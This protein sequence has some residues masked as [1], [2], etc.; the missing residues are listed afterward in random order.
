MRDEPPKTTKPRRLSISRKVI[1]GV[2]FT[3]LMLALI[4][5]T[6]FIS[7][8]R[9][10][11]VS[12]EVAQRRETLERI[13]RV[14]RYFMEMENGVRGYLL[15]GDDQHLVPYEHGQS[16]IVQELQELRKSTAEQEDQQARVERLQSSLSRAFAVHGRSIEERREGGVARAAE[17]FT[18]PANQR[19][20]EQ[21]FGMIRDEL[22][23]FDQAERVRLR[24]DMDQLDAI[25]RVNTSLV[26]G[27][28]SLTYIALLVACLFVLR[29]IAERRRAEDAL[30]M[31]RNL[32]QS[33]MDT[34]PDFIIVKDRAGKY[35]R[36]NEAYCRHL[37]L[38][39]PEDARSKT[40]FDF[41]PREFA[42]RYTSDE[43]RVLETGEP[44]SDKIEPN[45]ASDGREVWLETTI[46]PLR[47]GSGQPMGVVALSSDITQRREDDERLRHYALALKRSNEE[48][49][50]FASA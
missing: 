1:L 37:G 41:Y 19:E 43:T 49:Q 21:I 7:T 14:Q 23:D 15:S 38:E 28:T 4:A 18:N 46:V 32:L 11:A 36:I 13:E 35:L 26:A 5:L 33:I 17:H 31:E 9:F 44:Q 47:D 3:L 40:A 27:G 16:F 12:G 39:R 10:L 50:N 34:I 2:A 25:G 22:S 8:R 29:D 45:V 20:A 42:E 24:D 6:S 48:L 30:E